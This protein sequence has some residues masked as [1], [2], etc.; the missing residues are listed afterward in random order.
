MKSKETNKEKEHS[1]CFCVRCQ[2][3]THLANSRPSCCEKGWICWRHWEPLVPKLRLNV[4][5]LESLVST[6]GSGQS[7]SLNW[8]E[9][10]LLRLSEP[11]RVQRTSEPKMSKLEV[12][13][14]ARER[15]KGSS[16]SFLIWKW[17]F[18][19]DVSQDPNSSPGKPRKWTKGW[20]VSKNASHQQARGFSGELLLRF[21]HSLRFNQASEL[22]C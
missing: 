18:H 2:H 5:V 16:D 6:P 21:K 7:F 14:N 9:T 13:V 17:K 4:H 10:F 8:T 3:R 20:K 1:V 11:P 19:L 22:T 12:F 15:T